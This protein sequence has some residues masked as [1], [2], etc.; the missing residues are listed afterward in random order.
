ML[1]CSDKR[2]VAGLARTSLRK[3]CANGLLFINWR[4]LSIRER[5]DRIP[6]DLVSCFSSISESVRSAQ[7]PRSFRSAAFLNILLC[8][9][10]FLPFQLS[11]SAA[12]SYSSL[13]SRFFLSFPA[14]SVGRFLLFNSLRPN[15]SAPNSAVFVGRFILFFFL[16]PNLFLL[17]WEKAD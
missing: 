2:S 3:L 16:R 6:P 1:C 4:L 12:F 9:R 17:D 13:C 11:L 7:G 5:F 15:F 10:F 14:V 8:G